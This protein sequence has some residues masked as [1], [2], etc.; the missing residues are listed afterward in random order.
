MR[1]LPALPCNTTWDVGAQGWIPTGKL[2]WGGDVG[3]EIT[4]HFQTRPLG[5]ADL[6][7]VPEKTTTHLIVVEYRCKMAEPVPEPRRLATN[8]HY[9]AL[10]VG[11]P[12]VRFVNPASLRL[13]SSLPNQTIESILDG[14]YPSSGAV[15]ARVKAPVGFQ[16]GGGGT[17]SAELLT[18]DEC[19]DP[20]PEDGRFPAFKQGIPLV[21]QGDGGTRFTEYRSYPIVCTLRSVTNAPGSL[22]PNTIFHRI[23][24]FIRLRERDDVFGLDD[25]KRPTLKIVRPEAPEPII[26]AEDLPFATHRAPNIDKVVNGRLNLCSGETGEFELKIVPNKTLDANRNLQYTPITFSQ[27]SPLLNTDYGQGPFTQSI[28]KHK[29]K[30]TA[31][32][33]AQGEYQEGVVTISAQA[34]GLFS[35]ESVLQLRTGREMLQIDLRIFILDGADGKP[36]LTKEEVRDRVRRANDIWKQACVRFPVDKLAIDDGFPCTGFGGVDLATVDNSRTDKG[37]LVRDANGQL[38]IDPLKVNVFYT[39]IVEEIQPDGQRRGL[40]GYAVLRANSQDSWQTG[41][42]GQVLVCVL[43][44][45]STGTALAHEIGHLL[46]DLQDLKRP[47][48]PRVAHYENLMTSPAAAY[49]NEML[50]LANKLID[51]FGHP[52]F[53]A[54]A[55]SPFRN[56]VENQ[57]KQSRDGLKSFKGGK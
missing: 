27:T 11:P 49:S 13:V 40:G 3:H 18:L 8:V 1:V 23:D 36:V 14:S 2:S 19:G 38:R 6:Q 7:F 52:D 54:D 33:P 21:V 24:G 44:K 10:T 55:T 12:E 42:T 31:L 50:R 20:I 16:G 51:N 26:R 34:D 41:N 9:S 30:F 53:G 46:G 32:A 22:P 29:F 37:S 4:K 57:V 35:K 47:F 39:T 43:E 28:E 25:E 15:I 45:A 17:F 56:V 48:E 5:S